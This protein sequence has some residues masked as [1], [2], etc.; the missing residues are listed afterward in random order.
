[1]DISP[2]DS[3]P[4]SEASG[5]KAAPYTPDPRLTP[6]SNSGA[7]AAAV[8]LATALPRLL[9]HP[10]SNQPIRP[11]SQN[12][13]NASNRY[14]EFVVCCR[15]IKYIKLFYIRAPNLMS[16]LH[17]GGSS[18]MTAA[19]ATAA[20]SL[21]SLQQLLT[22]LTRTTVSGSMTAINPAIQSMLAS[23]L[24]RMGNITALGMLICQPSLLRVH[25]I[26]HAFDL[27]SLQNLE[28]MELPAHEVLQSLQTLLSSSQIAVPASNVATLPKNMKSIG[29]SSHLSDGGC[30]SSVPTPP[31]GDPASST[32]GPPTPTH[33]ERLEADFRRGK[34]ICKIQYHSLLFTLFKFILVNFNRF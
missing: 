22:Q 2:A 6:Q 17:I 34:I 9:S 5:P 15:S 11:A 13:P 27:G 26:H 23:T 24:G 21:S 29:G 28:H 1:M 25:L 32:N 31:E 30:Q 19:A 3:T 18:S 16:P 20:T 12:N 8:S 33:S 4:T 14:F 7:A 10:P